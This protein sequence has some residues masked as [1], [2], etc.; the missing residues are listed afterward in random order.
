MGSQ[1]EP[2][3]QNL[4][5]PGNPIKVDISRSQP[6]LLVPS[7][8]LGMH[9]GGSAASIGG[10]ARSQTRGRASAMGSQAEPGNQNI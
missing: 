10:I 7:L 8:W 5:E 9:P 2:G 4:S 1:A 3:N 6:F